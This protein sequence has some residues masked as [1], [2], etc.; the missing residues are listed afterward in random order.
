MQVQAFAPIYGFRYL[1]RFKGACIYITQI[2][3]L[4][5]VLWCAR[6]QMPNGFIGTW[7]L[8]LVQIYISISLVSVSLAGGVVFWN[9][10]LAVTGACLYQE[11]SDVQYFVVCVF[12]LKGVTLMLWWSACLHVKD[13]K[14]SP[15]FLWIG[16]RKTSITNLICIFIRM[17]QSRSFQTFQQKGP[18][19]YLTSC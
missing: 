4:H 18:I 13:S 2:Y 10:S 8:L 1:R 12:I 17:F 19:L 16:R 6:M 7:L 5:S 14:F 3:G 9:E 15:Q 11:C